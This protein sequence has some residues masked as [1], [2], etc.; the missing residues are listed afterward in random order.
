MDNVINKA[1]NE[2]T[3]FK[4]ILITSPK[5]DPSFLNYDYEIIKSDDEN[6]DL[7]YLTMCKVVILSRS[8][9]ALSSLFFNKDK[10]K[11]YIPL[12]GH[13]VCCGLNT[14][15]DKLDNSKIEY[16]FYYYYPCT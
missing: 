7:Y 10:I 5:S 3:D 14:I 15:Y 8:T 4:V 9:F 12:W 2:F 13:F 11:S 6:L 1:K 16:F